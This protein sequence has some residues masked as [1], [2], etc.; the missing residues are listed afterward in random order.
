MAAGSKKG[1]PRETDKVKFSNKSK[2][3]ECFGNGVEVIIEL[4]DD[5]FEC[6]EWSGGPHADNEDF[7]YQ[8]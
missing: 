6:R 8:I 5:L 1:V 4:P 2:P 7:N 3:D